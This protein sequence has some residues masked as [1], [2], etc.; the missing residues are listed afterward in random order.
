MISEINKTFTIEVERPLKVLLG[1]TSEEQK[2]LK[3]EAI[4]DP[5]ASREKLSSIAQELRELE[6]PCFQ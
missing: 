5:N 1:T 4:A 2:N 3:K 6:K